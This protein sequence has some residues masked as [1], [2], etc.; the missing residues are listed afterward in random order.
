M[1]YKLR[2]LLLLR[3]SANHQLPEGHLLLSSHL[4]LLQLMV[5]FCVEGVQKRSAC[6]CSQT[7]SCHF[8]FCFLQ[9][10]T[11]AHNTWFV[12]PLAHT[13]TQTLY[14]APAVLRGIGSEEVASERGIY[15]H[16]SIGWWFPMD[17]LFHVMC[18][19]CL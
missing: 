7:C 5:L 16:H 15:S 12:G 14:C 19:Y 6:Y 1:L 11:Q 3:G 9:N 17:S 18:S 2:L 4:L 10:F 13:Y 8:S